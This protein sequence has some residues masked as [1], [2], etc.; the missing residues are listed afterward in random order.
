VRARSISAG[1]CADG[2]ED[3]DELTIAIGGTDELCGGPAPARR[4]APV[5]EWRMARLTVVAKEAVQF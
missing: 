1:S 5:V 2:G 4:A 3:I